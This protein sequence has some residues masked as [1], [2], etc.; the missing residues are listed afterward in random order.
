VSRVNPRPRRKHGAV[1]TL[2]EQIAAF[3][4]KWEQDR[5]A[6]VAKYR[7]SAEH[8]MAKPGMGLVYTSDLRRA[9]HYAHELAM[10]TELRRSAFPTPGGAA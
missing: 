3:F 5:A 6:K 4:E 10:L 7:K 8:W 1:L 2:N 9:D